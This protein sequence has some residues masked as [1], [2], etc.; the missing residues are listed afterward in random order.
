M[1]GI[2]AHGA[3]WILIIF[4][5]FAFA[6]NVRAEGTDERPDRIDMTKWLYNADADVYYQLGVVYCAAPVDTAY[7]TMGFFV[8]G[9]YFKGSSVPRQREDL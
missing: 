1:K 3:G 7:Q 9:A 5:V 8:P 4:A 2:W 6:A